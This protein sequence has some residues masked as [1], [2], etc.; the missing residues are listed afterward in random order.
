MRYDFIGDIHG[1]AHLLERILLKLGYQ[2]KENSYIASDVERK[3][4]FLGDYIDRGLQNRRVIEIVRDMTEKGQAIALM[5][6]HEFNAICYHTPSSSGNNYL[7][8]HSTRNKKQHKSFLLE[9]QVNSAELEETISW[10]RSL[11]IWWEDPDVRAIH[12]CWY[13]PAREFLLYNRLSDPQGQIITDDW[14]VF[15]EEHDSDEQMNPFRALEILIKGPEMFLGKEAYIDNLG[16]KRKHG[17][18]KWWHPEPKNFGELVALG[19]DGSDS[20]F[21]ESQLNEQQQ[22]LYSSD[23]KIFFGHYAQFEMVLQPKLCCLDL[24]AGQNGP[25]FAY[26]WSGEKSLTETNLVSVFP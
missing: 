22:Y 17:R 21:S 20:P 25:L 14:E 7:R 9:Y 1:H 8:P 5:G 18:F 2:S 15:V 4:I 10:F 6:N 26:S 12:A 23:K 19:K 16:Y 13:E 11:P 24:R 3:V